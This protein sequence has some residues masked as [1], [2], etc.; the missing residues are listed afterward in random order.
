MLF[1]FVQQKGEDVKAIY[2]VSGL[3]KDEDTVLVQL[4]PQEKLEGF[5]L[6]ICYS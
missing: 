2:F 5:E 6:F 1:A 3:K 4:V